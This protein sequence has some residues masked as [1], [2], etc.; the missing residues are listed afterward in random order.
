MIQEMNE[1]AAELFRHA[2]KHRLAA[3]GAETNVLDRSGIEEYLPHRDPFLFV[4]RVV[5]VDLANGSLIAR[6]P[7][8]SSANVFAGHFPRHPVFPGVLQIEAIG[9]AALL[10]GFLERA[11]NRDARDAV[12]MTHVLGARFLRPIGAHGDLE[13]IIKTLPDDGLFMNAVGQCVY[14][15]HICSVAAI[16]CLAADGD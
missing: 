16:A 4:H 14:D 11:P 6:Y 15:G 3:D 5:H 1:E 10:W 12:F 2:T 13:I 7:L 9:Q 8:A